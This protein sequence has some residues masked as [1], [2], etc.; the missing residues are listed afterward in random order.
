MS[1]G[2][3]PGAAGSAIGTAAAGLVL[4]L[5]LASGPL[6]RVVGGLRTAGA[7]VG[8]VRTAAGQAVGAVRQLKSA[9]DGVARSVGGAG[10][11]AAAAAAGFTAVA[12]AARR[13]KGTLGS[14]DAK[15]GG[16]LGLIGGIVLA[17]PPIARLMDVFG[18]AMTV[19]QAVMTAINVMSRTT[20]I[21]AITGLVV[22]LASYLIDLAVNSRTGQRI[23][24]QVFARAQQMF[25]QLLPYIGP[26]LKVVATV[27][28]IYF[29]AYM[30]VVVGVLSAIS[31]PLTK[32][33]PAVRKAVSSASNAL[34]GLAS[35]AWNGLKR[36][37]TP[38]LGFLTKDVPRAFQRVR[39]ATGRTLN[40][41]AGFAR[42]A[43]Q[44]VVSVMKAPLDGVI[45]FANWVI[46][47][48]N[49]LGFSLL[50]KHFG[51]HLPKIPMLA[52][53]GIVLPATAHA[54]DRVR[55]LADLDRRHLVSAARLGTRGTGPRRLPDFHESPHAGPRG[56]AEDLLFLASAHA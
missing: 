30:T 27:V 44:A 19:A 56:V 37:V 2:D 24:Q 41:M 7:T 11:G 16:L 43:V 8:Q 5:D 40:G 25:T 14:L 13:L 38:V 46:D 32:G 17:C 55:P 26:V 50:G 6:G 45:G 20:P 35:S 34:R 33:F 49:S 22:P 10:R 9:V 48:L 1:A 23:I 51:V 54:A 52:E 4:S 36:A 18:T 15:F 47:G 3:T 53:G 39:D 21:G 28:G 12:D 31:A 29:T 42:T